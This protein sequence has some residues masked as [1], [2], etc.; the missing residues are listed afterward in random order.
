MQPLMAISP[1]DLSAQ[2]AQAARLKASGS[3]REQ[4][5]QA[6]GGFENFLVRKWLEVARKS[7]LE[8]KSGPMAIYDSMVDDQLAFLVSRQGGLGFVQP[9][10]EQ[11]LAQ[12]K[13]RNVVPSADPAASGAGAAPSAGPTP[14]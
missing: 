13:A 9:L 1:W 3:T 8:P 4:L 6:A 2:Q 14:D 7:S 12:I 10:V 11:M 5:T